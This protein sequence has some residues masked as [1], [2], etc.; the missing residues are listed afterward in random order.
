MKGYYIE[1]RTQYSPRWSRVNKI[2][3]KETEFTATDLREGDEYE[4]RV[5]AYNEAGIGRPSETTA[6][7][8]AKDPYGEW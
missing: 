4:F 7:V 6:P 3:N 1:K 8:R 5:M 2:L